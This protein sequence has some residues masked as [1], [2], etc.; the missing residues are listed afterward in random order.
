RSAIADGRMR[1]GGR[2]ASSRQLAAECGVSR[3]TAV[4]AYQRLV[5]EGYLVA[6]PGAGVFVADQP[7]ERFVL[8][9]TATAST[10]APGPDITRLDMRNYLLPLAPGMPALDRFPWN[11]W[12]RLSH[13]VC[14]E[15]PLNA[16]GY[17]EPQG[18]RVLRQTIAEY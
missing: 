3:T 8:R 9:A 2:V 11:T 10:A 15:R 12:A 6:R 7:P 16:I 14:R 18:E 17:A 1:G 5:A 13:Q 4:E